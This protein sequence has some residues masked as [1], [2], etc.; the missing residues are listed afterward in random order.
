[1]KTLAKVLTLL[2]SEEK[3]NFFFFININYNY[4]VY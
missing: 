1:M 3:K 2:S 4:G